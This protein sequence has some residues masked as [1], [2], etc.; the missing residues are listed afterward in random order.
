MKRKIALLLTLVLLMSTLQISYAVANEESVKTVENEIETNDILELSIE[1]AINLAIENDREMWK[2]KDGIKEMQDMRSAN[3]SAKDQIEE[4]EDYGIDVS[5][6][7]VEDILVRNKYYVILANAKMEE[8]EKSKE[9]LNIG[10][11]IETKSLYYNVLVAEK[12]IEINEAKLN[13]AKEQLRVISLKFDNGSATKAE[14]LNGEMAVQ[15]AQTDL[16][17]ANDDLN[18]AKLDLLNKLNLPFDTKVELVDK[19]LNYVP[20]EEINLDEVIET[21]KEERPEILVA[22]NNL[23][24][25]KIETHAYTAYYTSN[26]RQHKAAEEKLKDAELNIPQAYKDV[27][28]DVRKS[29]LNLI[30]AER[31]LVN[32]DKTVELAREAARINKLLYE[33]GMAASIDVIE[34]DTNLAQAEI[35]R[36]QLLVAYNINKLMFD[37]S[38]LI[39]TTPSK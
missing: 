21:A 24:V 34:A 36:Y 1:D 19:D 26:L 10:I 37:N 28:L 12:T 9:L 25:Q 20:T 16:D 27:E 29:Y 5:S 23:E 32:M 13:S 33:N 6:K 18:I 38:N 15:Q 8:L 17:S 11:E 30:K 4:L 14:V 22:E 31:A 7:S 3:K 39:G 35:G 2:I